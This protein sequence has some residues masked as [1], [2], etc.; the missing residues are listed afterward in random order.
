MSDAAVVIS[1]E[2]ALG[3]ERFILD[4]RD[5]ASYL[6]GHAPGAVHLDIRVWEAAGKAADTDFANTGFWSKRIGELGIDAT[7][8]VAVHDAGKQTEAARVW[9]ILQLF[10][11]QA[12][13]LDGGWPA[14]QQ[15]LQGRV[16]TE[17]IPVTKRLFEA[18]GQRPGVGVFT[19]HSLR[20]ALERHEVTIFD[21]RTAAEHSGEDS[22]GN[23]R[24]G[25]LP[26]AANISHTDLL[27]GDGK[28][29]PVETLRKLLADAGLQAGQTIVTHCQGGGRAALAAAAAVHA[30]FGNVHAYYLSFGDW[31][32]DENCPIVR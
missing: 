17:H 20:N 24:S 4:V 10:G 25:H 23:A 22:R 26:G 31:A 18:Y 32:A 11:V 6:E 19:R 8:R 30:G 27:N 1:A 13:I 29:K 5:H 21:A 3:E 14:L 2:Q 15:V 9:F 16:E 12:A 28:L 7:T